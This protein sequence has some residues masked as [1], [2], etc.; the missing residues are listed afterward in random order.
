V[1]CLGF[2]GPLQREIAHLI[3]AHM[4]V[5]A[6]PNAEWSVVLIGHSAEDMYGHLCAGRAVGRDEEGSHFSSHKRVSAPSSKDC[7]IRLKDVPIVPLT[8]LRDSINARTRQPLAAYSLNSQ[9]VLNWTS[10]RG[11]FTM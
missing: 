2:C 11:E 6:S 9:L 7:A 4:G 3:R 10:G 8:W 1:F 5:C